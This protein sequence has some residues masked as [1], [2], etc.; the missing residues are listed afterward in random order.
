PFPAPVRD[1]GLDVL[2]D[3]E[4]RHPRLHPVAQ[5][6]DDIGENVPALAH[7]ANLARRLQLDHAGVPWAAA[8]T[9]R[10]M[11]AI[12]PSPATGTSSP[13]LR[14]QSSSG[15]VWRVYTPSRCRTVASLSSSR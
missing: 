5:P 15:D 8:R 2:V 3:L 12:D 1:E 13:R 9:S 4:R 10:R 11:S 7:E 6:V 14:Y